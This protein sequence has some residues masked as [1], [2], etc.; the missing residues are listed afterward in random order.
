[1]LLS[2]FLF[3]IVL[4]SCGDNSASGNTSEVGNP[5]AIV[6][7]AKGNP[8]KD[9]KVYFYEL[10]DIVSATLDSNFERSDSSGRVF[11]N[12]KSNSTYQIYAVKDSLGAWLELD[13]V[14]LNDVS[15]L[16][17]SPMQAFSYSMLS[18]ENTSQLNLLGTPFFATVIEGKALFKNI[19]QGR[20]AL[21]GSD[22]EGDVGQGLGVSVKAEMEREFET[23]I[24]YNNVLLDDFES[25]S[26][27]HQLKGI[28]KRGRWMS[29]EIG[30]EP[31]EIILWPKFKGEQQM[32]EA[33]SDSL[34][35]KGRSLHSIYTPTDS[36]QSAKFEILVGDRLNLTGEETL[37][38]YCKGVGRISLYLGL[39]KLNPPLYEFSIEL[40][41]EWSKFE[42][43]IGAIEKAEPGII[44]KV[45]AIGF[46]FKGGSKTDF[47]L[48][49]FQLEGISLGDVF[50]VEALN[51]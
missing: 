51:L 49:D 31:D 34:A 7:D 50:D 16:L 22:K 46:E 8:I 9:A 32:F 35:W 18:S 12:L 20:Y 39:G 40:T 11:R 27:Y 44:G 17:L 21:I 42:L 41:E 15:E 33:S 1:M 6:V 48:D 45:S 37:S 25:R 26:P 4:I 14:V 47:W 36:S 24:S 38:F 2:L 13:E 43:D 3:A 29:M 30:V 23:S 19:P 10:N 5:V 28:S